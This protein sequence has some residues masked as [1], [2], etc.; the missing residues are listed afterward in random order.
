MVTSR[1]DIYLRYC[2]YCGNKLYHVQRLLGVCYECMI[3]FE[4]K[5]RNRGSRMAP[6]YVNR[7]KE[8]N[9]SRDS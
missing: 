4:K 8:Q 3:A 6:F 7:V 9:D 1:D 5:R 2:K